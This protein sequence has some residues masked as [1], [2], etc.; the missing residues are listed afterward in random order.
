MFYNNNLIRF[1]ILAP[2]L[3]DL[4]IL[5]FLFRKKLAGRLVWFV[6]YLSFCVVFLPVLFALY[7]VGT[8]QDYFFYSWVYNEVTLALAF[9]VILEVYRNVLTGYAAVQ[10]LSIGFV[11]AVS[12]ALLAISTYVGSLGAPELDSVT[13]F[14]LVFERSIRIVQVGLIASL[15]AFV[16][17]LGLNWKSYIF[18]IA[19]GY[20][21]Y[22]A[23]ALALTTYITLVGLEPSYMTTILEQAA[24]L[25]M[26]AIWMV[27]VLQPEPA[28][29]IIFPPSAR[30]DLERWNNALSDVLTR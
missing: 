14:L 12:A 25:C 23:V 5:V 21:L 4:I 1:I 20:G 8:K 19:L 18:G 30:Q 24:Y 26:L 11:I 15:F 22:A 28:K 6:S 16:R 2:I 7:Q 9:M 10:R 3:P 17:L 13:R 29:R 27:Y